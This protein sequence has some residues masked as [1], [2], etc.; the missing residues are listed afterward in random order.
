MRAVLLC[1]TGLFVVIVAN[2]ATLTATDQDAV[3]QR[4]GSQPSSGSAARLIETDEISR[5]L[6][7]IEASGIDLSRR[8]VAIESHRP[9]LDDN[10]AEIKRLASRGPSLITIL[11]PAASAIVGL[12]VGGWLNER[13]QQKRL[14]QEML[15]A[16]SR[17]KLEIGSDVVAW[18]LKQL[19]LLY[20]PMRAL[21]GQSSALYQQMNELL[22]RADSKRFRFESIEANIEA[23]AEVDQVFEILRQADNWERFRTVMHLSEVYGKGLGVETYF[24]E[25]V[26]I[27]TRIEKIIQEQAGY[28][29]AEDKGLMIVFGKYLAHFAVLKNVHAEAR[30]RFKAG[31]ALRPDQISVELSAA[32]GIQVN[33]AAVF[34]LEIHKLING[35]FDALTASVQSW[36]AQ[37]VAKEK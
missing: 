11:T 22:I 2:A 17:A 16:S 27:G 8:L 31:S 30:E 35:G 36:R 10:L 1:L 37:A 13:L 29:R 12:L 3:R 7:G 4:N 24:D 33:Q 34:P 6:A 14:A 28:A 19:S 9:T 15:L 26:S 23:N 32:S 20:G 21:L 5:R 18:E 25:I